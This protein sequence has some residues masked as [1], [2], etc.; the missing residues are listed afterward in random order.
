M[1]ATIATLEAELTAL[2]AERK[3]LKAKHREIAVQ[4]DRLRV[5]AEAA[6]KVAAMSPGERAAIAQ[7]LGAQGIGASATV[8]TPGA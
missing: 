2:H 4:L 1:A 5:E 3:R 7:V 6:R 8:G